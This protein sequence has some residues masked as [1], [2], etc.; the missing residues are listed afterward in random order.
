MINATMINHCGKEEEIVSDKELLAELALNADEDPF[1]IM[2]S[3][4]NH[5]LLTIGVG[6]DLGFVQHSDENRS[7]PYLVATES[8]NC[9]VEKSEYLE[10]SLGGTLTQ[11]P[12][13]FCLPMSIV[14]KICFE[15][16]ETGV[17]PNWVTWT[18]L[19]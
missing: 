17:L 2:L 10:F 18:P 6:E 8:H 7:L 1:V 3:I 19:W 5:G 12:R 15:F 16:L 14:R 11:I 4:A 9:G 13:F